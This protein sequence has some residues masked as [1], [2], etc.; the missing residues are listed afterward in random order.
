MIASTCLHVKVE[1]PGGALSPASFS[2]PASCEGQ[3]SASA[4]VKDITIRHASNTRW[5]ATVFSEYFIQE[6]LVKS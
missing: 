4:H 3:K 1:P 5:C 6:A 2:C